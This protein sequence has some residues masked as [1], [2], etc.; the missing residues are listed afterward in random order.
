MIL[1]HLK[2]AWRVFSK[3]KLYGVINLLGLSVA[4]AFCLLVSLYVRDE[5]SYDKFHEQGDRLFLLHKISFKSDNLDASPGI[6]DTEPN[7]LIHK[8]V[9]QPVPMATLIEERIPEVAQVIKTERNGTSIEKD[10]KLLSEGIQYVDRSFFD[11]FTYSF[12]YGSPESA[13]RDIKNA[14]ITKEVAMKY[15]GRED[16]V[17][18][19]LQIGGKKGTFYTITGVLENKEFT[20]FGLNIVVPFENSYLYTEYRESWN[21]AAIGCF[22]MLEEGANPDEVASKVEALHKERFGERLEQSRASLKL[23]ADNPVY[24]FG[25][26]NVGDLYLN[27]TLRFGKSSSKLYSYILVC[28]ALIMIIIA[29]IN[30]T[31]ISISLS[32]ARSSEVALRKVMGSSRKQLLGQFYTES[33]LMGFA[34]VALGYS[35]MQLTLPL[36]SELTGKTF[37]LD[38]MDQAAAVGIGLGLTLFLSLLSGAY[39]ARLMSGLRIVQGLKGQGTHK[40]KP[41][42][43]RTMVVFQFTLCIFFIGMGLSMHKQFKY[44]SERDL[45]FDKDQVVYLSGAWGVT[46]KLKQELAKEPSVVSAVGAGGI[47]G[48]GR[49]MG[50]F[51]SKGVEYTTMRVHT[52][53]GFLET[54]GI[55]LVSG[56]PFDPTRNR[57]QEQQKTIV[58]ETYY[59][60]LKEDTLMQARL[61]N[62][63][64]VVKDFHFESLNQEIGPI[65]FGLS[66]PQFISVMYA[67]LSSENVQEGMTA[68][69]RAW[70]NVAPNRTMDL[71]FLDE[72]LESNYKDSQRWSKIMDVAAILAV[73]IAC[74][75]L[76]G[77][78]AINAMNRMKEIG[79]RK[80]LGAGFSSIVMLLNKQN[81]WLIII[82]MVIAL[83][84]WYHFANLWVAG[85]AYHTNIGLELFIWAGLLCFVIVILT[86]SFHSLR[87]SRINPTTLLRTE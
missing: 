69:E 27:P 72:Y 34:A 43:I 64:G 12:L 39:P 58:N 66:E 35:L 87:T 68:I 85:F 47:F 67:R 19:T 77:L 9:S 30:Y 78:T 37:S 41:V 53:Y 1:N 56:R 61:D 75:G 52:D 55:E 20:T 79:I 51:V 17:G 63:I 10:G 59:N 82:S 32:S 4:M 21:Y 49:S 31:A 40:I 15:F 33:F 5:F 62:I 86:V 42:L 8:E 71:R 81:I 29:S 36:F 2:I 65:E 44:I 3:R 73:L 16:V 48:S 80:V 57:E 23:S 14:V 60:L 7:P 46:D 13:L 11:A 50:R 74:S 28:V 76:F 83:P 38:L 45:G 84:V 54:M 18:E 70:N 24:T 6:L 25:L 22:L 26:A